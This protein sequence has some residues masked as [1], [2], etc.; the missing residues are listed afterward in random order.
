M[1]GA[2]F[3]DICNKLGSSAEELELTLPWQFKICLWFVNHF[4]LQKKKNA[5]APINVISFKQLKS[6]SLLLFLVQMTPSRERIGPWQKKP[7]SQ[8]G[9]T[10]SPQ[11]PKNTQ[12]LAPDSNNHDF[13]VPTKVRPVLAGFV[14][15]L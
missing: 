8:E 9:A 15:Y 11:R 2:L 13:M 1:A 3:P 12:L 10:V 4:S 14:Q 5:N 7:L 6:F